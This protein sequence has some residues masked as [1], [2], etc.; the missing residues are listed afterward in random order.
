MKLQGPFVYEVSV[1]KDGKHSVTGP[2]GK[3]HF[4]FPVT[5]RRP[6]LYAFVHESKLIYVGQ[7]KQS[8][9]ARMRDGFKQVKKNGYS[10]YGWLRSTIRKTALYVWCLDGVRGTEKQ[11]EAA[12]ECI[13]SEVVFLCRSYDGQWPSHQTEIHFHQTTAEHRRLATEVLQEFSEQ[14]RVMKLMGK[15]EWDDSF[16]YKAE[17]SRK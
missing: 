6:K 14:K 11:A 8:M 3:R 10:G 4:V 17:R 9:S 13:E 12:L 1:D 2:N 16:K 7:T 15:L 5:Q